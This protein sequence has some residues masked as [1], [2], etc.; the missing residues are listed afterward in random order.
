MKNDTRTNTLTASGPETHTLLKALPSMGPVFLN[1]FLKGLFR[2]GC[3]KEEIRIT[4][5]R[6]QLKNLLSDARQIEAYCRVCG[7]S[8]DQRKTIPVSYFQC[9]FV[10]LLGKFIASPHFPV[11]PLG[12]IHTHQSFERFRPVATDEP[13]DLDCTLSHMTRTPKGVES[14]FLLSASVRD[15]TVWKGVSVFLTKKRGKEKNRSV[16]TDP[17]LLPEKEQIHVAADTGRQY[18]RVSGDYNPHH[19]Y[20]V[21]ARLFG[22]KRAIAH[23]MWSLGR[24]MASLENEFSHADRHLR[25]DTAFKR[26][27][28]MPAT[29]SLGFRP[30]KSTPPVQQWIQFELRDARTRVPHLKGTIST[31]EPGE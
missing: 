8:T 21:L 31:V 7:F 11:T 5:H 4:R 1:A 9:L 14:H 25:V 24:V 3:L 20:P 27:V 19:L 15:E 30:T 2:P 13:L 18:A 16:K 17:V 26:P 29:L 23:G 28:F 12:L 10:G 6:L 22:F